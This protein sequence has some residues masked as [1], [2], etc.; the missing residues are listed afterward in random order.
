MKNLDIITIGSAMRDIVFYTAEGEVVKNPKKDPT[1]LELIG[2][3]LGAKL[4]SDEVYYTWGGGALNTSINFAGLGLKTGILSEVGKDMD[5]QDLLKYL[6]A[7]KVATGLVKKSTKQATGLSLL[8]V[9]KRSNEHVVFVNY[10][11]NRDLKLEA[12]DFK[13]DN[14]WFYVSSLSTKYWENIMKD[15]VK[16]GKKIAWNPGKTQLEAGYK[17]LVN[18]LSNIE[19]LILN[20]DEATELCLSAK[21]KNLDTRAMLRLI[22]EWGPGVVVITDGQQGVYVYDGVKIYKDRPHH[23]KPKD[24][25]GA[26]D[27]FAS[28]FV[29][30]LIKFKG[31]IEKAIKVGIVNASS[32]VME[33]GATKGLLSWS[34]IK[35]KL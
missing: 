23:G 9:D 31:D 20:K 2:F 21:A 5:G 26:G 29:A 24:T 35:K 22:F 11:A 33:P 8:V 17:G 30:G 13:K 6:K 15:L 4:K 25:T 3:E 10:G 27:C 18:Y 19:V 34:Q 7:Q 12:K 16:T 1:K 28:S 32:L 14:D